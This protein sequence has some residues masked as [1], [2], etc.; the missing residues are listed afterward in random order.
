MTVSSPADGLAPADRSDAEQ[1][2]RRYYQVVADLESTER[3][4][5][6]LVSPDL[7]LIEHPNPIAPR[8]AVHDL[9]GALGGFH[10]GKALLREQQF[11][12]RDVIVAGDHVVVR[13]C[14]RGVVGVDAGPYFAGQELSAQVAGILQ[15]RG[16]LVT[17]HETYDCYNPI[18]AAPPTPSPIA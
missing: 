16:G 4:L 13:A 14:W 6:K 10:A 3:D 12:V 15:I 18:E 17:R 7:Q 5:L 11:D 8:G 9:Q 1:L 2:V